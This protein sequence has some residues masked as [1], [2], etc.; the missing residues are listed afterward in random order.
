MNVQ[1]QKA[2]SAE[3]TATNDLQE[4]TTTGAVNFRLNPSVVNEIYRQLRQDYVSRVIKPNIEESLK[5]A[6]AQFTAEELITNAP[7]SN[8]H[9]MKSLK[10]D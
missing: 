6:T 1:I 8:L 4:V 2:E 9:S 10:N 3:S 5:A 7:L